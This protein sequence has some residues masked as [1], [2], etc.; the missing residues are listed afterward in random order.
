MT[1]PVVIEITQED[2]A[3]Y[4]T[5]RR[6]GDFNMHRQK[7]D[8][9]WAADLSAEQYNEILRNYRQYAVAFG[10]LPSEGSR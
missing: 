10:Y 3:A 1:D 5:V 8:A 7:R 2:F 4:E 9:R 6:S